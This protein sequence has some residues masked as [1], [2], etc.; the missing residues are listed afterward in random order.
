MNEITRREMLRRSAV[1]GVAGCTLTGAALTLEACNASSWIQIALND[2][3][4]VLQIALAIINI[5]GAAKGQ[6]DPATIAT[7]QKLAAEVQTDLQTAQT[8]IKQYQSN[9]GN[10][11][12]QQINAALTAVNSNLSAILTALHINNSTLQATIAAAIGSAI[13]IVT[14]LESLVPTPTVTA[15]AKMKAAQTSNAPYVKAA[16]N[17]AVTAAGGSQYVIQ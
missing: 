17:M 7:A 14:Y 4:T 15:A 13:S 8:L 1:A 3:P 12:L 10:T 11:L 16:F 6:V 9:P 5:V 2:L